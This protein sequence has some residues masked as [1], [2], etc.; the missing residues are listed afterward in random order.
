VKQILRSNGFDVTLEQTRCNTEEEY[1]TILYNLAQQKRFGPIWGLLRSYYYND[2]L[3]V[4]D[5]KLAHEFIPAHN[6]D[7]D[8]LVISPLAREVLTDLHRKFDIDGDSLL[9]RAEIQ[10]AF[11]YIPA[12]LSTVI[13][14]F[15]CGY[16]MCETIDEKMTLAGWLSLWSFTTRQDPF[17]LLLCLCNWGITNNLDNMFIIKKK[18]DFRQDANDMPDTIQCYIFGALKTGKTS[19]MRGLINQEF[20]SEYNKTE[21]QHSVVHL[22]E[23]KDNQYTLIITEFP[24]I[25]V[26]VIL[27]NQESMAKCDVACL[28]YDANDQFSFLYLG[29]VQKDLPKNLPRMFVASKLDLD[30]VE[31]DFDVTPEE[32]C[33]RL[34]LVRPRRVSAAGTDD[35]YV[36]PLS[37]LWKELVLAATNPEL[38]LPEWE[39]SDDESDDDNEEEQ[40]KNEVP[41]IVKRVVRI[42]LAVGLL[43]LV[44]YAIYRFSFK[45]TENNKK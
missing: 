27:K 32:F 9:S 45:K 38:A 33:D 23:Y 28:V 20:D 11:Q 24:D 36:L 5:T 15:T 7:T 29:T 6:P 3:Q 2:L 25:D 37:E 41:I 39:E 22:V 8:I 1:L 10:K 34:Q 42:G 17:S 18:R 21:E 14:Q 4:D 40:D 31:Q 19:L 44:G 16:E 35:P 30:E 43:S 12:K 13:Q 26:P